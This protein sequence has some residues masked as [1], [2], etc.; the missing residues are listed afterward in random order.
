MKIETKG[1][2][3]FN[4]PNDE[5]GREFM[6]LA[7]KFLNKRVY[8]RIN[9][10]GR[11]KNR[12][13]TFTRDLTVADAEWFAIYLKEQDDISRKKWLNISKRNEEQEKYLRYKIAREQCFGG[14]ILPEALEIIRSQER[15]NVLQKIAA[16]IVNL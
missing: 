13:K 2:Q 10:R 7:S 5:E 15:Q 11:G 3:L 4:V 12:P 9:K 14:A 8:Q 1:S 6:R 16:Q